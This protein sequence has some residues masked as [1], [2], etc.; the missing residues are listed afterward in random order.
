MVKPFTL[1]I[2]KFSTCFRYTI[3]REVLYQLLHCVHFFIATAVPSEQGQEI[4]H[5]LRQVTALAVTGRNCTIFLVMELQ[6]E[7]RKTETITIPF[8]QFAIPI[9]FEQ[10]RQVSKLRHG[11]FPTEGTVKKYMQRSGR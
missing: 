5:S 10:Q 6:R 8:T 11:L 9:G 2:V 3:Q 7:N 1:L 4:N